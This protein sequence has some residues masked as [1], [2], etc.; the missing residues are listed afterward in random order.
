MD[1]RFFLT[2]AGGLLTTPRPMLAW[3]AGM[4]L[5]SPARCR[6]RAGKEEGKA[7]LSAL[8]RIAACQS[9]PGFEHREIAGQWRIERIDDYRCSATTSDFSEKAPARPVGSV[10]K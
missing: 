2:V 8:R 10:G 3:P 6:A 7:A 4:P 5:V 9:Q 1:R